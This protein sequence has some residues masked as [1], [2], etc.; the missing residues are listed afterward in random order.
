LIRRAL[1]GDL[2]RALTVAQAHECVVDLEVLDPAPVELARQP[3]VTV[4]IDLHLEGEPGLQLEVD[5]P[6]LAIHE[7][8]I[9]LQTLSPARL[10]E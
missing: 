6:Q 5:E 7:V 10:D 9:E 4:E 3:L 8:V 2:L 1:V